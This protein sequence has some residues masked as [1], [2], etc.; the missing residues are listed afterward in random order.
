MVQLQRQQQLQAQLA[1]HQQETYYASRMDVRQPFDPA[2]ESAR[3]ISLWPLIK[4]KVTEDL[5]HQHMPT[6]KA[7]SFLFPSH[8]YP[9]AITPRVSRSAVVMPSSPVESAGELECD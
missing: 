2:I 9:G 4:K 8:A 6:V 7:L 1:Q 5:R 3:L